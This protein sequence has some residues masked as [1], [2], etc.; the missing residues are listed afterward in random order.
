[1]TSRT[2]PPY[3][4]AICGNPGRP[5]GRKDKYQ[6]SPFSK[7]SMCGVILSLTTGVLL[8]LSLGYSEDTLDRLLSAKSLRCTFP[9]GSEAASQGENLNPT[10]NKSNMT[11]LYDSIDLSTRRARAIGNVGASTELALGSETGI[12]FI[13]KS[14]SGNYAFTTVLRK[15]NIVLGH[16]SL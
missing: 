12:T 8:P 10:V 3:I 15:K 7:L 6:I 4:Q 16:S 13:E 11:L 1:M 9:V 2:S 14:T 5:G